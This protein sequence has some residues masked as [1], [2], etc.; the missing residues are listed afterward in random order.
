MLGV[1]TTSPPT[2]NLKENGQL[3]L[4]LEC[5]QRA[6]DAMGRTVLRNRATEPKAGPRS[7]T[8]THTHKG[9]HSPIYTQTRV[10]TSSI[11]LPKLGPLPGAVPNYVVWIG[12]TT[13]SPWKRVGKFL[14]TGSN[15]YLFVQFSSKCLP[16]GKARKIHVPTHIAREIHLQCEAEAHPIIPE[17]KN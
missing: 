9:L 10:V 13:P 7:R 4:E 8:H 1:A 3:L 16:A 12:H 5:S 15:A 6:Q 11:P 2:P 14:V 17:W